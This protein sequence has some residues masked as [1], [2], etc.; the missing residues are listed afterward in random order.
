MS[1]GWSNWATK[2]AYGWIAHDPAEVPYY[3]ALEKAAEGERAFRK[4]AVEHLMA[5]GFD[6]ADIPDVDF[7]EVMESFID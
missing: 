6:P 3:T 1:D 7:T 2:E 5:K 4:W